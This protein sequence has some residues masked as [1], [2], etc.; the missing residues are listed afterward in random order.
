MNSKGQGF[1]VFKLLIAA[2]VAVAIL[3][4]LLPLLV[5]PTIGRDP[6]TIAAE[7]IKTGLTI[8]G[9]STLTP[10]VTFNKDQPLVASTLAQKSGQLTKEQVCISRGD[11]ERNDYFTES[12]P[13]EII[14]YA[15]SGL[16]VKMAVL[17]DVGTEIVQNSASLP[18]IN[19]DWFSQCPA[20]TS[21]SQPCCLVALKFNN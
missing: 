16:K 11:F 3:A 9:T 19:P 12:K 1:E 6:T 17:C 2:I 4:I 10:D 18:G 5:F 20:C 14:S 8:P 21:N 15:G 13:G 7:A